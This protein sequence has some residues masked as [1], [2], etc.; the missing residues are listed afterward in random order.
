MTQTQLVRATAALIRDVGVKKKI[1]Y[2]P[3]KFYVSDDEGNTR[4]FS[5]RKSEKSVPYTVEDVDNIMRALLETI[6]EAL[7]NGDDVSLMNFGR[8]GLYYRKPRKTRNVADKTQ[9]VDIPGHYFPKFFPAG[10]TKACAKSFE[11]KLEERELGIEDY[12]GREFHREF[13]TTYEYSDDTFDE[14][15]DETIQLAGD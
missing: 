8:F 14:D 3:Q 7:R 10:E 13:G 5:V 9:W 6:K 4:E 12:E 15:D 2:P 1:V 11:G